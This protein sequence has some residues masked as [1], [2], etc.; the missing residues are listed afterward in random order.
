MSHIGEGFDTVAFRHNKSYVKGNALTGTTAT[1]PVVSHTP[2]G[3]DD[4]ASASRCRMQVKTSLKKQNHSRCGEV[5]EGYVST[6]SLLVRKPRAARLPGHVA[7][8][9]LERVARV[10]GREAAC[11]VFVEAI[12]HHLQQ[13]VA[14]RRQQVVVPGTEVLIV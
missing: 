11:S 2:R 1:I 5:Y 4:P 9:V 10:G 14:F 7:T 12:K 8:H 3:R 13:H 6:L